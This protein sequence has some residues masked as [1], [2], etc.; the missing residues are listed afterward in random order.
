MTLPPRDPEELEA[1]GAGGAPVI[2][3]IPAET[4][5]GAVHLV[6]ADLDRSVGYYE[7]AIGL[8]LRERGAGRACLGAGGEDLLV[9]IEQ[10]GVVSAR[11]YCGLYHFALLVPA[12]AD[13]ARWLAHAVRERV[14]LTGAADHYVS[15][16][17]YLS[18]P[19][20]H[21]I[22]IYWD[23]PRETW[24][25]RVAQR[26]TTLPL[27][28]H[29]LLGELEDSAREP[30]ERLTEGAVM[31]HVHLR[32]AEIPRTIAFYRE[33]LGFGLMARLGDQAAFLS[34][35][36]YHHHLGA[37]TWE[38]AGAAQPPPG[39]ASLRKVTVVL[40]SA[41]DRD[42]LAARVAGSEQTPEHV[43]EGVLVRD[44]SGNP[45]VLAAPAGGDNP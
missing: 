40:P 7:S 13:L 3:E 31:G 39:T 5:P 36:G 4:R 41:T 34:A 23:R 15:E 17:I 20:D 44:P 37:N 21:G 30:F 2:A 18:D 6:V 25:G 27:D 45:I 32:V 43:D 16:A 14:P 1:A 10:P 35:G 19:D 38:S 29:G 9:L 22:E 8:T 24:E 42:R 28:T 26:M 11:G 33:L 12:R